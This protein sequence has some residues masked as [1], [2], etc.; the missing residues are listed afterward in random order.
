ML[1]LIGMAAL[2]AISA[3]ARIHQGFRPS[4]L[5]QYQRMWDDFLAFQ[6]PA[7]L[8]LSQVNTD[9]LLSFM[10][11]LHQNSHSK[12][13]LS[14]YMAAI[15]GFHIIHGLQ[16][17]PFKDERIPLFLK[18]LQINTPLNPVIVSVV[19][20]PFL[21]SIIQQC[22]SLE[23]PHVFQPLYLLCFFSF[24]RLSN[25]LPHSI[26]PFDHTR[27]LARGDL[28][29]PH[30]GAALVIKWSKTIQD[31][32]QIVTLPWLGDS[33]LCPIKALNAMITSIPANHN[34][35]LFILPRNTHKVPL[36]D[37][38]ARKHLKNH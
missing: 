34:D 4:T 19:D 30:A 3:S 10:E 13:H 35:P 17:A 8:P 6:V 38:V 36:T 12:P 33:P 11:Y 16:T 29:S 27:Q 15:R 32:K 14:N 31:R 22:Q 26:R 28:I 20:I 23:L 9:L 5:R 25:I 21:N 1:A 18:F 24:L 7:G 37:S 2:L